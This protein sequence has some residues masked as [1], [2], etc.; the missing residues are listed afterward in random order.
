VFV[1]LPL[2]HT[3]GLP[4][5]TSGQV[6]LLTDGLVAAHRLTE[7]GSIIDLPYRYVD[8]VWKAQPLGWSSARQREG[9]TAES[10]DDRRAARSPEPKYQTEADRAAAEQVEWDQQCRVCVGLEPGGPP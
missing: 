7:P 4:H 9:T 6:T 8:D 2:G 1:D 5:D 3:T 10:T